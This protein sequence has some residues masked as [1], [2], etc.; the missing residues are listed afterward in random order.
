[1][2]TDQSQTESGAAQEDKKP[3]TPL[4]QAGSVG[5]SILNPFSDLAVLYRR[6]VK[7]GVGRLQQAWTLLNR[8]KTPA[9]SL[10]WSRAVAL[11]GKTPEQLHT[12]FR[13]IQVG[14][15]F[16]MMSAGGLAIVLLA[17]VLLVQGLPGSTLLRA[18]QTTLVL[19]SLSAAGFVKALIATYRLWQ[20][21]TRRVSESEGGTFRDFRAQNRWVR[22]VITLR[23][24]T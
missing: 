12:N 17:M 23:A 10:D 14:W 7:P 11:S 4:R 18:V 19:A 2:K 22:Q 6:G 15:W 5:L 8:E 20:L 3:R 1:M 16:L 13:R 9:E 24:R 21:Q